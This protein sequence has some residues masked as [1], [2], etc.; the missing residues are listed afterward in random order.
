ML[1]FA[2]IAMFAGALAC[3]SAGVWYVL[4]RK[5]GNSSFDPAIPQKP[6]AY[7][8]S[9]ELL[10]CWAKLEAATRGSYD[11]AVALDTLRDEIGKVLMPLEMPQPTAKG[12]K[13]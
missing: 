2:T 7:D 10:L 12:A 9:N 1:S 11:A 13:R 6:D 3:L 4:A 5:R 8:R